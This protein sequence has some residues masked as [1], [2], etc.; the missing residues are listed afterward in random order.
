MSEDREAFLERWSRLKR[1]QAAETAKQETAA[2]PVAAEERKAPELPPLEQLTPES[3]FRPFMGAQVD[4]ETR[5]TALK[6]L[7]TD[8]HFNV[9]DPFEAYSEDYTGGEPIPMEML[10]TLN[11]A[12]KLLFD[13]P[14]KPAEAAAAQSG[15]EPGAAPPE[16]ASQD[17]KDAVGKQDA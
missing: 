3:D 14:D 16:S 10:K 13:D 9:P 12:R 5:R 2:P 6:T 15:Q 8:S 4:G 17:L 1:E 7:F 11:H